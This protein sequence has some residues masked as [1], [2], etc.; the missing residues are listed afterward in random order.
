M[1]R[2]RPKTRRQGISTLK[3]GVITAIALALFSY[4][5][6]AKFANPFAH[7][8][9]LYAIT[10]TANEIRLDSLVRIAGVN[11]GKLIGVDPVPGSQAAKLTIEIDSNGLPIHTDA[12]LKI[13]PRIFL[14]GNFFVDLSP[15]SPSAPILKDGGTLAIQQVSTPVQ[16]DQVLTALQA[17]TRSSLRTLLQQL[18]GALEQSGEAFNAS[19][20]YWRPAYEYSAIVSRATL[21]IHQHDLSNYVTRA[22]TVSA[23]LD[24]NPPALKGLIT[25]FDTTM[26]AFARE[27]TSLSATIANLPRTLRAAGPA[28]NRLNAAFPPLERLA[29]ALDPGVRS[30]GPAIDASLPFLAQLR[31]LVRPA[32]LR[33]LLADLAVTVP[34]L[35]RLAKEAVP[36]LSEARAASSCVSNVII[37]WSNET[38]P[39]SHFTAAN[40]FPPPAG[41]GRGRRLPPRPER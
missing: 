6:Y 30:T 19:I 11:V 41:Q 7:H 35:A 20:A 9:T 5:G 32:E 18:G 14:E 4:G 34:A 28:L 3:A 27:S 24:A 8:F 15:G 13:R 1:K 37:P 29:R 38:V 2:R 40:G 23:S 22:A 39:D 17:D 26:A 10:P 25:D 21:G 16:V 33:G 31:L 12:T 36:L